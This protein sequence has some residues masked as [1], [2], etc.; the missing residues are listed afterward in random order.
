V[1][2]DGWRPRIMAAVTEHD[3]AAGVG[4]LVQRLCWFDLEE[5]ALSGAPRC[6]CR[7]R[8]DE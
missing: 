4:E 3:T 2:D 5:M 6:R 8:F 1:P 7:V